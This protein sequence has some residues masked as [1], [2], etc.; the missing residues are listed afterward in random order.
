M[1]QKIGKCEQKI[2]KIYKFGKCP[3]FFANFENV[4]K[5]I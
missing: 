4:P 3:K 2:L 5:E 1:C